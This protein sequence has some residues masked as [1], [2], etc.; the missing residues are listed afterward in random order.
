MGLISLMRSIFKVLS[1]ILQSLSHLHE[2]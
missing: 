1:T 2:Q